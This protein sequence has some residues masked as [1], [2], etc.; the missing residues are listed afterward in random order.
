[1]KRLVA[2]SILML[3]AFPSY[4]SS[5]TVFNGLLTN[6][7]PGGCNTCAS[8]IAPGGDALAARNGFFSFLSSNVAVENFAGLPINQATPVLD[9]GFAGSVSVPGAFVRNDAWYQSNGF[10]AGV[11]GYGYFPTSGSNYLLATA[12]GT[13]AIE[14]QFS[15]SVAAFGFYGI[16]IGDVGGTLLFRAYLGANLVTS[17]VVHQSA[18]PAGTFVS[19]LNGSI[20][21]FGLAF[22]TNVFDRVELL[23]DGA[24]GSLADGF[25]FDEMVV[26]DARDVNLDVVPEPSTIVLLATGLAGVGL[27]AR[28]RRRTT[29]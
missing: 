11:N 29:V 26:A 13:S 21:F 7:N 14:L 18:V 4:G 25:L 24:A 15:Q 28:R 8:V 9:F 5:Q 1:M 23:L 12:S 10:P 20:R 3:L 19:G 2:I 16:D 17:Q 6:P 27:A 22:A